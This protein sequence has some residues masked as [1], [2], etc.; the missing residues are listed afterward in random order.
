M[1][2]LQP[3]PAFLIQV[4]IA[5]SID[6]RDVT[7][8]TMAVVVFLLSWM[9]P[10]L[11]IRSQVLSMRERQFVAVAKLSGMNSFEIIFK[12]IIK[13]INKES[14]DIMKIIF[15]KMDPITTNS[16]RRKRKSDVARSRIDPS[17]GRLLARFAAWS[18]WLKPT[19]RP[20]KP[21]SRGHAQ[22]WSRLGNPSRDPREPGTGGS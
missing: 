17:A 1:E 16:R 13:E 9:A 11:V 15:D 8:I 22:G 12:E 7:I 10:T 19:A 6:K 3:T 2:F 18:S 21:G 14:E 5:S 4:V 20:G